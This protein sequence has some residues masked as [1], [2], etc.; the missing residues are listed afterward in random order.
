LNEIQ[1]VW[2]AD[3]AACIV[4]SIYKKATSGKSYNLVGP[5]RFKLK[6]LL[7][8]YSRAVTGADKPLLSV[9]S[10]VASQGS[11]LLGHLLPA[12]DLDL[13]IMEILMADATA[14]PASMQMEFE[15]SMMRLE[16][17]WSCLV[18]SFKGK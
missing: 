6:D 13:E 10:T 18:D 8:L 12:V 1:P 3:V 15:V 17:V 2:V 9:P 5:E 16:S 11:S 4:Q 14:D 7:V